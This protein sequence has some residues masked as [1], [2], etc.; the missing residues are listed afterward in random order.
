MSSIY[1]LDYIVK[2]N[3]KAD[4]LWLDFWP[5]IFIFCPQLLPSTNNGSSTRQDS[6]SMEAE[7]IML[8]DWLHEVF[9]STVFSN[10]CKGCTLKKWFPLPPPKN[11][12]TKN[13]QSLLSRE[14][15]F[16]LSVFCLSI[17]ASSLLIDTE[18]FLLVS[19]NLF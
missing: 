5:E 15:S 3:Q 13:I 9:S 6:E 14:F 12:Q 17:L 18:E 7:D 8:F 11:K 4:C 16:Q 10:I 1:L 2:S 19:G